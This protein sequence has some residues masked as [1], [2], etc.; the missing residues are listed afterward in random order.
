VDGEGG[1]GAG[2][3]GD[4]GDAAGRQGVDAEPSPDA[5]GGQVPCQGPD[6]FAVLFGVVPPPSVDP[7][8]RLVHH[9]QVI[10]T[11]TRKAPNRCAIRRFPI[12]R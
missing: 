9:R 1:V 2:Q 10:A 7:V 5:G 3:S 4:A 8:Q 11:A 12:T 6:E